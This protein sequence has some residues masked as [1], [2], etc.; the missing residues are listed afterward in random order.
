MTLFLD[1]ALID[2][3]NQAWLLGFVGGVTTNPALVA[4]AGRP[5]LDILRDILEATDGP[6]FYQVT[7]HTVEGRERQAREA[8]ALA[9]ER[10]NVKIPATTENL[11][12]AATLTREGILCAITAVS[13][14]SQAYVAVEAG[15]AYAIPYVSRLT[16]QLG[17]GIVV[18]RQCA[19]LA[20]GTSTR[21]LAASLKT[22][23][24]VV[25]AV[26]AGAQDITVPLDILLALGEHELSYQAIEDFDRAMRE[27]KG[28]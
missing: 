22:P 26:L 27:A 24:E 23:Q 16:R 15:C 20:A 28:S 25:E 5:G 8:A 18:L 14:P 12:M 21:I 1:S 13:H 3:V 9:L 11:A 10:V 4:K 2:E 19:E 6:V 7:D 17:D